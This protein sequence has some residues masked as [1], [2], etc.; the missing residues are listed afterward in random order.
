MPRANQSVVG[1]L[2][3]GCGVLFLFGCSTSME[4]HAASNS[5]LKSRRVEIDRKIASDDFG[6]GWG[7][8]RWVSHATEKD[9]ILK[10]KEQIDTELLRRRRSGRESVGI[11]PSGPIG[12]VVTTSSSA[13]PAEPS[14]E[15]SS[16]AEP[17]V[18]P[19]P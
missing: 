7:V 11:E 2:A 13:N 9:K 6:V 5:Q 4:M 17:R 18:S 14:S 8:S 1:L 16:P 10:E 19:H 12:P 3:A 15:G